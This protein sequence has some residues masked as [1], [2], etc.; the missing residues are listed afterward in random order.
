M[1]RLR[2]GTNR[3]TL[4]CAAAVLLFAGAVL[5]SAATPVRER[6][7]STV[8]RVDA[9]RVWLDEELLGRWRDHGWWPPVVIAALAL[10]AVLFLCWAAAQFRG[11]RLRE[12]PLGQ[13]GVTLSARALA[14]A[15]AERARGVDGVARAHVRLLGHPRRL[16]ARITLV[17]DPDGSPEA[18]LRE[19]ARDTVAEARAA[20]APRVLEADVHLTTRRHRARRIH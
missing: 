15:M 2:S 5:A 6:L 12:L 16:R 1:S 3:S 8:P 18:V 13:P 20:A 4:F 19:L 10:G 9:D 17:L 7:P 11:G 14:S